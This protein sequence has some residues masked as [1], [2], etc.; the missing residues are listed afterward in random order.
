M[1]N[2]KRVKRK[3]TNRR[4]QTPKGRQTKVV[5]S[6]NPDYV[7][8]MQNLRRS[9]ATSPVPSGT[10]YRRTAKYRTDYLSEV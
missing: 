3:A 9:S 2:V 5:K 10:T 6:G 7:A 1:S 4:V 8:G